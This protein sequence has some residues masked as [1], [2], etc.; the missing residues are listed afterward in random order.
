MYFLAHL[1]LL[2]SGRA[3]EY[4]GRVS[5]FDADVAR[6]LADHGRPAHRPGAV[7]LDG[8]PVVDPYVPDEQLVRVHIV[9][10]LCVGGGAMD[11]LADDLRGPLVGKAQERDRLGIALAPD[12]VCHEAR[13]TRRDTDVFG[14]LVHP[15]DALHKA[16]LHERL[17]LRGPRHLAPPSFPAPA[18]DHGVRALVLLPGRR[19]LG[20]LAPRRNGG[21]TGRALPL[22]A[23]VRV[24]DGVHDRTAHRGPYPEVTL[25]AG[26]A[27][28]DVL[29]RLVADDADGGP[30]L[31]PDPAA[32]PTREPERHEVTLAGRQLGARPRAAG[33]LRPAARLE[34]D[35]VH[36][37]TDR[38]A[39]QRQR[40]A[41]VHLGV[42]PALHDGPDRQ[43]A[44]RE[45]VALLA[46][47]VVQEGDVGRAVRVV[48]DRRDRRGHPVLAPLEVDQTVAPLVA[49]ADVAGG[50]GGGGVAPPPL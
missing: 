8:R 3:H 1:F 23:T 35:G 16:L 18:H 39:V 28:P 31:G 9:V 2:V 12:L 47:V 41:H 49:A 6:T 40:V 11:D 13:L 10:V 27:P 38:Y 5:E 4:A 46:V 34:L 33:Q 48:L 45:D 37:G 21:P 20:D 15:E 7:T 22:A 50:D 26:F 17:F 24:V 43:V 36:D 32:L 44:G 30:A 29:V 14:L 25:A 42:R 19:A